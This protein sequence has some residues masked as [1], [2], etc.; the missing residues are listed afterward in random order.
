M[1][2]GLRLKGGTASGGTNAGGMSPRGENAGMKGDDTGPSLSV[3]EI[4]DD[5]EEDDND[6]DDGDGDCD[7]NDAPVEEAIPR[8]I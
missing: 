2:M 4:A 3:E 1:N 6:D 8:L 5:E 7:N